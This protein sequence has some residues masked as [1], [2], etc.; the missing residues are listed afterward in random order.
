MNIWLVGGA[1]IQ[2]SNEQCLRQLRGLRLSDGNI[3]RT[4]VEDLKQRSA[5]LLRD[6]LVL[7][8]LPGC[9]KKVSPLLFGDTVAW[10]RKCWEC[11]LTRAPNVPKTRPRHKLKPF[12]GKRPNAWSRDQRRAKAVRP[13]NRH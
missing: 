11:P 1:N 6:Q 2:A 9:K 4:F 12:F 7:V 8:C 13:L 3:P 5:H 10:E